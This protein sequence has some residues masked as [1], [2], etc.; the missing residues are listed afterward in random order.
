MHNA[1]V[2]C[3]G[4]VAAALLLVSGAVR[5]SPVPLLLQ[6]PT[7][8]ATRIAFAYGGEIWTVPRSGGDATLLV[9]GLGTASGPV[10]SPDVRTESGS[11][12]GRIA[13]IHPAHR[14]PRCK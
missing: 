3:F 5:A 13:G 2:K 9:G 14:P 7:L 1:I 11:L 6:T 8:S 12:H 4:S 10:F